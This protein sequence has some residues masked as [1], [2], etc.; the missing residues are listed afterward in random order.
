MRASATVTDP[1]VVV[2]MRRRSRSSS[3]EIGRMGSPCKFRFRSRSEHTAV[4]RA[5]AAPARKLLPMVW[6]ELV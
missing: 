2:R 3:N 1:S 6:E 5:L 4:N